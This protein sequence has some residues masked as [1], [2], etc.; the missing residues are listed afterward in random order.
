MSSR[1]PNRHPRRTPRAAA[2]AV[3]AITM[4]L[5]ALPAIS[6]GPAHARQ[7]EF[8]VLMAPE[9]ACRA[10]PSVVAPVEMILQQTG[11]AWRGRVRVMD[12]QSDATG[13]AWARIEPEQ[14]RREQCWVPESVVA[15]Y[16]QAETLL[17]MAHRL[18]SAE[19]GAPLTAWVVALNY[20]A[21]P[22]YRESVD[23]STT[24]TL[25][26]IEL[27]TRA[28][29][30]AQASWQPESP[31][32]VLAWLE[33]FGHEVEYNPGAPARQRWSVSRQLL[34][35][36]DQ[37]YRADPVA[38]ETLRRL[39]AR[40]PLAE[41]RETT[42]TTTGADERDKPDSHSETR[43]LAITV[44]GVACRFV[45]SRT[46][47]T[48][49]V[50]RLDTHF[51][52]DRPDSIVDGE[53]WVSVPNWW[54]CW[55]PV[56]ETAPSETDEH[57]IAIADR[58]LASGGGRTLDHSLRVYNV[59]SSRH[60]GYRDQVNRSAILTLRRLQVLRE[61]L[62]NLGGHAD[63]ALELGWASQ[64]EDEV[65]FWS[66]GAS[67]FVREE[68]IRSAFETHRASE[69]AEDILWE[70]ATGPA[71]RDCEGDF[72]CAA[73]RGVTQNLARYWAEYPRGRH[74]AQAVAIAA[75][76]LNG[77]L[78]GCN[79]ALEAEPGSREADLW[80]WMSWDP[81]G[82]EEV[83]KIRATLGEVE[84]GDKAPLVE[85]LDGLD[86]CADRHGPGP[87]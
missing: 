35:S 2:I 29:E 39:Q 71:P 19:Y 51:T 7:R 18:L 27:L 42:A 6:T 64:L 74:V 83:R 67:W 24:L 80:E 33:S 16:G 1:T 55:I 60:N 44:P 26:R 46:A 40:H 12:M 73:E 76:R 79:A 28:L 50:H 17:A 84:D 10:S 43:A 75:A 4:P 87:A 31:P 37:A 69:A 21:H 41:S 45:P 82:A 13:V 49:S 62:L 5:L 48:S 8:G 65:R 53:A 47:R 56:S 22:V 63:G 86:L 30:V 70:F 57:L 9:V 14:F 25:L 36:L 59:L 72:S 3:L 85:L 66:I 23:R 38:S 52:T 78:E 54:G 32:L 20:F 15:P 77:F 58:F 61:A 81:R 68:A 11:N 34:D